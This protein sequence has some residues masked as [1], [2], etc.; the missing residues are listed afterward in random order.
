[1]FGRKIRTCLELLRP[2]PVRTPVQPS[3]DKKPRSF[4]R[5]DTVY[6]KLYGRNGWKWVPG[7]VV[8]KIG[9]VMYNVWVEDH[10]MLRSHINQLRSRQAAGTTPKQPCQAGRLQPAFVAAQ[11]PVGCL[12]SPK[13][14]IRH[15]DT[16]ACPERL[17]I[18][19]YVGPVSSPEPTLLG[20]PPARASSTPRHEAPATP[21]MS[22]SGTTST[23]TEFESAVEV[24]PVVDLPRRSSRTRRPPV[25]FDPYHLY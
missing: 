8:E 5:N 17:C 19:T 4:C 11:H 15:A 14:T 21:S 7:T 24:E 10:R 3:D 18:V 23:S 25:R 9:D 2:P 6:A 16:V 20:S 12:E 13:P 1:M 22:S